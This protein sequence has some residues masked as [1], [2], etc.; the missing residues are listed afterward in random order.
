MKCI[1]IN[2]TNQFKLLIWAEMVLP[3]KMHHQKLQIWQ[4]KITVY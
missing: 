4:K 1:A 3:K 2:K